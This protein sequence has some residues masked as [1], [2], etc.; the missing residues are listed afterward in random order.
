M[1]IAVIG[2]GWVT[3][4]H[5]KAFATLADVEVVGLAGRNQQRARELTAGSRTRVYEDYRPM[6]RQEKPD[7]VLVALPPHLHGDVEVFCA[8]HVAAVLVEKPLAQSLE[9]VLR[10]QEAFR[11]AGTLVSV[12]YQNRYRRGSLRARDFFATAK[13]KPVLVQGWWVGDIPGPPWWRN[14]AQS[15]GQFVEQCTHVVDLARFIVG[16]ID[17]VQALGTHSF[18]RDPS[19]SVEDAVVVNARF[20][21][22]ALGQFS[23]GC[24]V[25]PGLPAVADIGLTITSRSAVVRFSSWGFE[26]TL[27]YGDQVETFAPEPDIFAVQARAFVDA[28][29]TKNRS[30]ILSDY[31]DGLESLKVGLAANEA[32]VQP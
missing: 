16:D 29:K 32:L 1:R 25:A 11:N 5:L 28:W 24:F 15:A 2:T 6:I 10:A 17:Q 7:G 21:S 14:K 18:H 3:G 4:L 19:I 12:G 26:A 30:L 22:G 20:A 23:T 9:P 8:D 13:D 31:A 27:T